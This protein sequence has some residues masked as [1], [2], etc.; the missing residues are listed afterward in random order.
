MGSEIEGLQFSPAAVA[1]DGA[2]VVG[3]GDVAAVAA[4][5]VEVAAAVANEGTEIQNQSP[6][7]GGGAEGQGERNG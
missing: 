3:H 6:A 2:A 5:G 7:E 1:G 4:E